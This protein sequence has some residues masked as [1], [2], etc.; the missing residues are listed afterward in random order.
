MAPTPA[1]A[2]PTVAPVFVSVST[3]VSAPPSGMASIC[4]APKV[5]HAAGRVAARGNLGS[6]LDIF[7]AAAAGIFAGSTPWTTTTAV[8]SFKD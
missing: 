8:P 4:D 2:I 5:P 7:S 6:R 1:A 3:P